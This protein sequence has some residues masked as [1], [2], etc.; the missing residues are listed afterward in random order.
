MNE[1][2]FSKLRIKTSFLQCTQLECESRAQLQQANPLSI[3]E[4]I[5][6]I[7]DFMTID[8][9]SWIQPIEQ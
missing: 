6:R 8:N 4:N 7:Q 9:Y 3:T 1:F 5:P 2:I